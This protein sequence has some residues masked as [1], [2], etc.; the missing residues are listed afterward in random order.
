MD[1]RLRVRSGGGLLTTVG[2]V[3]ESIDCTEDRY[4]RGMQCFQR[5]ALLELSYTDKLSYIALQYHLVD[6]ETS[7]CLFE[8]AT[9]SRRAPPSKN[10]DRLV[11]R[12]AFRP[13]QIA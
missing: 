12:P 13:V 8:C 4:F 5:E 3:S 2:C 7:A 11:R 6:I 1:G 9:S 10:T